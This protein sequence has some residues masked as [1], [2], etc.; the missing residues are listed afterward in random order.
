M[1]IIAAAPYNKRKTFKTKGVYPLYTRKIYLKS[2]S[3]SDIHKLINSLRPNTILAQ[4][5]SYQTLK[6]KYMTSI[7]TLSIT[8]TLLITHLIMPMTHELSEDLPK[9]S[10]LIKTISDSILKDMSLNEFRDHGTL[11]GKTLQTVMPDALALK[12]LKPFNDDL[13]YSD[14]YFSLAYPE[15]SIKYLIPKPNSTEVLI[16]FYSGKTKSYDRLDLVGKHNV[17]AKIMLLELLKR[18]DREAIMTR[19]HL[20]ST[21][22]SF[23][24]EAQ[25]YLCR[26][27]KLAEECA[28]CLETKYIYQVMH[29]SC[30]GEKQTLC[31]ECFRAINTCP[32]CR[33]KNFTIPT[34]HEQQ[35]QTQPRQQQH[36]ERQQPAP[37]S[38]FSRQL[39]TFCTIQ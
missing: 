35:R 1:K 7:K 18:G 9:Q 30:C 34:E 26:S 20:K 23:D 8:L 39:S 3:Y 24:P 14:E 13:V 5:C 22:A 2:I 25:Y 38:N 37:L 6:A 36:R 10:S 4:F 27:Y 28:I 19:S 29:P 11:F 31:L 33:A 21:F 12:K 16:L 17:A 15:A 32:F